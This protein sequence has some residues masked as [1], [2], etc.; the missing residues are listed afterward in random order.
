M[1]EMSDYMEGQ[2]IAHLFR[3]ST[4]TKPTTIAIALLTTNAVDSDTGVFTGG[5]GV[6]VTN[7]GAYARLSGATL[8]N[9][10]DANWTAPSAGDGQTDNAKTLTFTQATGNWGTVAAMALVDNATYNTGNMWF[11]TAVDTPKA[12]STGDTAEFAIGAITVTL[13]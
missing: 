5:T 4:F 2:L 11:Y 1:S 8:T 12:I 10:L 3:T 6:E 13:A 9:P 7:A